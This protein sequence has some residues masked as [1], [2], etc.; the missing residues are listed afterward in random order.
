MPSISPVRA[1]RAARG[2]SSN[3]PAQRSTRI[4]SAPRASRAARAPASSCST[5]SGF[6]RVAQRAKRIPFAVRAA[7]GLGAWV[8]MGSWASF[9]AGL[10]LLL[11]DQ[12]EEVSHLVPLHLEV[13]GVVLRVAHFDGDPLHHFQVVELLEPVDLLRVVGHQ[14]H[15]A[16][17]AVP[18]DLRAD[19]V[20]AQLVDQADAAPLL[21]EVHQ[22]A[23]PRLVDHLQRPV[24]LWPA[25]AAAGPEHVPRQALGVDAHQHR[26]VGLPGPLHE[27]DVVQVVDVVLV[28]DAAHLPAEVGGHPGLHRPAHQALPL[29]PVVDHV[30]DAEDEQAVPGRE[31]LQI[32][33]A[34]HRSVVVHHLADDAG[35]D[36]ARQ[37]RQ[38]DRSF[39]L[40]GAHQHAALARLEREYVPGPHH[41]ARLGLG[42]DRRLDGGGPV[43]GADPGGDSARRLD[44][45]R[46]R[47]RVGAL[48]LLHHHGERQALHLLLGEAQADQ[49]AGVLRHEVDRF[50]RH[51]LRGQDQVAF[52]LP[53]GV[54]DQDHHPP[55]PDLPQRVLHPLDLGH[56]RLPWACN[57][58]ATCL[59]RMSAST[60]TRSP[61]RLCRQVVARRV[62]GMSIN[63]M[64]SVP[65][66][67]LTVRLVPSS[68]TE[69]F[70]TTTGSRSL[71]SST[72][73][74][75]ASPA[76]SRLRMRPTPSTCPNTRWPPSLSPR[77]RGRSRFT[78][79][80]ARRSDSVVLR[81]VSTD[82]S[83][84][85]VPP[86]RSITVRQAPSTAMLAPRFRSA[87]GRRVRTLRRAPPEGAGATPAISPTSSTSPVN[88]PWFYRRGRAVTSRSSPTGLES[89]MRAPRTS[90]MR[91]APGNPAQ[92]GAFPPAT[93]GAMK[94]YSSSQR[95]PVRKLP[96]MAAPPSTSTLV[97][98]RPASRS[99]RSFRSTRPSRDWQ[100][101]ISAPARCSAFTRRGSA[102]S[103]QATS[104]GAWDRWRR[105][106]ASGGSRAAESTTT[107]TGSRWPRPRAVS[108]GSSASAVPMPTSTASSSSRSA[109]AISRDLGP[110][111]Q[112]ESPDAVAS[113][114]SSVT[115]ALSTTQGSLRV[116]NLNHISFAASQASPRTPVRTA[117]PAA[118]SR[119][120]PL[121]FTSGLGSMLPMKT[122]AIPAERIASVQGGVRPWWLQGSRVT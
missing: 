99:S 14:A 45:H 90:P 36:Q 9:R 120:A 26:L 5:I 48:V 63:E 52:V 72:T 75:T 17:A 95:R 107:R 51:V 7:C 50:G 27:R 39:R 22:D 78:A 98:P 54:V 111:T 119:C 35:G 20:R 69:P 102:R 65:T 60:F 108:R 18:Q 13:V 10:L 116:M 89:T 94:R 58:R 49:A 81:R 117:T 92:E 16:H 11:A 110:D 76:C 2:P 55:L 47:R 61:L 105:T 85:N 97:R 19:P 121:P 71:G 62:S 31:F 37:A 30:P 21:V 33:H 96:W 15:L 115:A 106:R 83:A 103:V 82:T 91:R 87:S 84:V 74:W 4:S 34:R 56:V 3:T 23:L 104:V 42:V 57:R 43:R 118:R 38:V 1:T 12:G 53:V 46:E 112:R 67:S 64:A 109:C 6:Q 93:L 113:F 44:A 79:S 59:A 80:P 25:V 88:T 73:A 122:R 86:S 29:H 28:G 8:D 100:R 32:G 101:T 77:A 41:V 66:S 70:S 24:E 40:P 68:A 114:P